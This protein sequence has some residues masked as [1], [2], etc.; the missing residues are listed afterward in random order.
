ML[1]RHSKFFEKALNGSFREAAERVIKWP[2][3]THK[4]FELVTDWLYYQRFLHAEI[5]EES[6]HEYEFEKRE[7]GGLLCCDVISL[8]VRLYIFEETYAISKLKRAAFD[9][10]EKEVREQRTAT[11][12]YETVIKAFENL[13]AECPLLDYMVH[14]YVSNYN[15]RHDGPHGGAETSLRVELPH[16]FLLRLAVA[17]GTRYHAKDDFR[18]FELC[19]C[20]Q[21]ETPDEAHEC[22]LASPDRRK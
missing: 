2:T 11:F 16:N 21:H 22:W 18:R 20:H 6:V 8:N 5:Y 12:W 13:P 17:L 4:L 3:E 19:R 7:T 9:A 10:I 1:C 14:N 15:S